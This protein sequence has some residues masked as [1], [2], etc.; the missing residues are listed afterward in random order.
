MQLVAMTDGHTSTQ[1]NAGILR[2]DSGVTSLP[3]PPLAALSEWPPFM[4]S[5]SHSSLFEQ[6]LSTCS[7]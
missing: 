6:F 4:E 1:W 7:F 2:P 3:C 5:E